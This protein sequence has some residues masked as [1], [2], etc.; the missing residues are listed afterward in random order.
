[1]TYAGNNFGGAN[2]VCVFI[3]SGSLAIGWDG[4]VSPC[5]P[6]LYNHVQYLNGWRRLSKRHIVGD[7]NERGLLE[8]W[9]PLVM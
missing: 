8:L 9:P 6:L 3:E 4:S 2:D 5:P 1:M 7:V